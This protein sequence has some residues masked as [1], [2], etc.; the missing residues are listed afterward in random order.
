MW[1]QYQYT[2]PP[3]KQTLT[4]NM[5]TYKYGV[6]HEWMHG[7]FYNMDISKAV[8]TLTLVDDCELRWLVKPMAR[9][10]WRYC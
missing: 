2:R 4:S 9:A 1:A 10:L 6:L 8:L 7:T 5:E 3:S